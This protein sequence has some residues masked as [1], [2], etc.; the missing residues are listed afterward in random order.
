MGLGL[1]FGL[2][3]SLLPRS[4][5][6]PG[7]VVSVGWWNLG[8][9]WKSFVVFFWLEAASRGTKGLTYLEPTNKEEEASVFPREI[10]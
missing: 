4:L 7:K 9:M 8:S 6:A 3:L 2:F 5:V 10:V 1:Y